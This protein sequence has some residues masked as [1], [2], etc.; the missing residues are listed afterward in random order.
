M[1]RAADPRAL[2]SRGPVYKSLVQAVWEFHSHRLTVRT[3]SV[4]TENE[5]E[6]EGKKAE[7]KVAVKTTPELNRRGTEQESALFVR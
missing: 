3:V 6:P 2:S 4:M 1:Q 7:V 5:S